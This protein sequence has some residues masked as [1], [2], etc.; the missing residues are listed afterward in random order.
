MYRILFVDDSVEYANGLKSILEDKG[1][2]IKY[3]DDPITGIEELMIDNFDLVISDYMMDQM[4]GIRLLSTVKRLKPEIKCMMLTG[5]P[6]EEVESEALDI[7]VDKYLSKDKSLTILCKHIEQLLTT[8]ITSEVE[9]KVKLIS[10]EENIVLDTHSHIVLKNNEEVEL[11][12]KEYEILKLLLEN[13]GVALS[14]E[15]IIEK[16]WAK[17]IEDV[18]VRIV[19]THIKKLRD[20]LKTFAIMTI[21]GFGYK[22]SE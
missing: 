11:T 12:R 22:W 17:N 19:D 3:V 10:T 9:T 7:Y 8:V 15:S 16:L 5:F 13:K 20:K 21:R 4:T 18:E 14:R 2:Y 6:T 1:Y